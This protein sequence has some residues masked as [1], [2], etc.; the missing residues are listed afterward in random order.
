MGL[1]PEPV[2]LRVF[3][4]VDLV[5]REDLAEAED[6]EDEEE[7]EE[8]DAEDMDSSAGVGDEIE[9]LKEL[10]GSVGFELR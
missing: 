1:E 7:E 2:L 8:A 9:C 3:F 4:A 6:E 5:V 10:F